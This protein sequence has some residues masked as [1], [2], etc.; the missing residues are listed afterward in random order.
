MNSWNKNFDKLIGKST[1]HQDSSEFNKEPKDAIKV[2]DSDIG[3][4]VGFNRLAIHHIIL[5]AYCR[6]SF[7]HAKSL[8]E[9]FIFILKG[10]PDLWINGYIQN[11]KEGHAVGFPAGTGVAHT[12]INNTDSDIYLLVAGEK[13][14][15]ENLCSFPI[16]PELKDGC[17]FWWSSPPFQEIGSHNGLPG[18]VNKNDLVKQQPNCVLYCPKEEGGKTFHYPGN[19]ETFGEGFR[20]TNKIGLK[21]LGIWFEHL[22][23][24]RRSSFP[25]AH[26]HEEEF[27]YVLKGRLTVWMDG[28]SKEIGSN[29]FAAFPSNTGIAHT[30]INNT[31]E[32]IIYLCIGET[33]EFP[34]EKITYP[35]N[36]L[37]N[38]ECERKGWLWANPPQSIMGPHSGHSNSQFENHLELRLCSEADVQEVLS[39]FKKSPT[40][41][42]KVDGCSPAEKTARHAIVDGPKNTNEMYF[43]EFLIIQR[44]E[45]PI[46]V[47]DLHA[48]HPEIGICYIGL[49]LIDEELFGQ[50]IGTQCYNFIEDY[51]LRS[52]ECK[53]IRLGISAENNV[54]GF[55]V[56]MGFKPSGKSYEWKGEN[57]ITNVREFDKI[58]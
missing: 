20:I 42:E 49:L 39:I 36:P 14:K 25:H 12:F 54:S 33:Q 38:K 1:K 8:E 57:K 22:P 29:E 34:D 35:L 13:T 15:A 3:R 52:Y 26:T 51:I 27:V 41:F 4:N 17:K 19:N 5:P 46:G 56:K 37:R 31:N 53:Q 32:D 9:E 55:W 48:N 58:L 16:N 40:Y 18:A 43:N 2:I 47:V 6:T 28:F 30:V 23:P 44:N 21:E 50:G 24:G 45:Q 7:P 11:L 10:S